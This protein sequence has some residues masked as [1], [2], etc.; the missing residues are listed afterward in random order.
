MDQN[1][2]LYFL[3]NLIKRTD[4]AYGCIE[5]HWCEKNAISFT[6]TTIIQALILVH[7]SVLYVCFALFC[8]LLIFFLSLCRFSWE[9][10]LI[11]YGFISTLFSVLET[12]LTVKYEYFF[13]YRILPSKSLHWKL[14]FVKKGVLYIKLIVRRRHA[15][16]F[17]KFL[18]NYVK[19]VLI[20][21]RDHL[22][23]Y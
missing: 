20:M 4:G 3:S 10:T 1:K 22:K 16:K 18:V 15:H 23:L 8:G 5:M 11:C 6:K 14:K 19:N 7:Y 21:L 13:W 2:L 17:I 12:F 9:P